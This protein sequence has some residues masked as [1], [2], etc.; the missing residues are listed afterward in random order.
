M[1][2]INANFGLSVPTNLLQSF[3]QFLLP[4][5][6]HLSHPVRVGSGSYELLPGSSPHLPSSVSVL[7]H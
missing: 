5:S 2:N 4:G 3:D 6:V 7:W 1:W